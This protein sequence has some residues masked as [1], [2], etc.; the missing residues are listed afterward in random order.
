MAHEGKLRKINRFITTHNG[1]GKAIFSKELPEE[2]KMN[3]L[4]D[5]LGFALRYF[6]PGQ[7]SLSLS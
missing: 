2:S 7:D 5:N 6:I 1:E 4:P 3:A